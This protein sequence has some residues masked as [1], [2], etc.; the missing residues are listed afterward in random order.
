MVE[1]T[2]LSFATKLCLRAYETGTR[3]HDSSSD[4]RVNFSIPVQL[5]FFKSKT[6]CRTAFGPSCAALKSCRSVSS[7]PLRNSAPSPRAPL[8]LCAWSAISEAR[9]LNVFPQVSNPLINA[10]ETSIMGDLHQSTHP[11]QPHLRT[12]PK[13]S[14]PPHNS[15]RSVPLDPPSSDPLSAH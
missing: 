10:R 2:R 15:A 1:Q 13:P 6:H 3:F 12:T 5:F 8:G 14:H 11:P 4:H 7:K 9:F